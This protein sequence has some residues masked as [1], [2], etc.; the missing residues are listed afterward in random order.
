MSEVTDVGA[1]SARVAD[2]LRTA[3]LNGEIVPGEWI[4]QE[5]VAE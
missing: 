4:R 3:I 1:A 2:Y 5:E